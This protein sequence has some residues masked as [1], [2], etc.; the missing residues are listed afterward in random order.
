M[1]L[2]FVNAKSPD[3]AMLAQKLDDYYFEVVGAVQEKYAECNKPHN[4]A[5]LAVVYEDGQPIGCGCWKAVDPVTAELKRMYVLPEYRRKG[6]ASGLIAALEADAAAAGIRRM[7]LE[8]AV[9][10]AD[11]IDCTYPPAT[12]SWIITAAPPGKTIA[13]AFIKYCEKLTR[14]GSVFS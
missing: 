11:S 3:F 7:I 13:C 4:F 8:T 6:V 14:K 5:C 9:D 1:E 10:T 2:K 12:G